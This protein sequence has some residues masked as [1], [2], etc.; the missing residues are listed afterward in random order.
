MKEYIICP[1]CGSIELAEIK[2]TPLWNVY[3][4]DCKKCGYTIMESEWNVATETK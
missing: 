2:E 3:I 1:E 4:H